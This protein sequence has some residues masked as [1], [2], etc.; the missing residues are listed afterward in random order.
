MSSPDMSRR[1]ALSTILVAGG[2]AALASCGQPKTE[3]AD[4]PRAA[5]SAQQPIVVTDQRGK[6]LTFDKPVT[7]VV[8]IPMPAASLL[9]A[10]D[11]SAAHLAAMHNASWLAM[12]DG[13][14]GKL[15][16]DAL[17]IPHDVAAN[18][19]TPN[20]ESIRALNPDVVVQW[21][22]SQ[23]T[24]PLENAGL[25]VLGLTNT[26]KQEDVDAWTAMFAAML[27]KPDRAAQIKA[28]SDR[29]RTNIMALTASRSRKGPSILYFNRFTG[30][31]K[32]A[33]NASYNDFYIKLV[34]GTNPASGDQGAKGSGMV[35]VDV[36]Q[37]LAWDPEVLLLG[38]FDDA[39]PADITSDPV[40]KDVSA[41]RDRR[42]YKVPLGGYRWDPPGQ[43]SPLMWRWLADIAFPDQTV[44]PLRST[45]VDDY[46]FL[47]GREPSSAD[48]DT[49]LWTSVN[50]QSANYRQ[51][52]G[53]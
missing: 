43:E 48:I 29:T 18:D 42:V 32:V 52:N 28:R 50:G 15:F 10:V 14:M 24:E 49:M 36:E 26:G 38:N 44:S 39:L 4:T 27:G 33:G 40:W 22:D 13:I 1:S 6:T 12:R 31:L 41:V 16:P 9:V 17:K 53:A 47:Y 8:T 19:F 46:K 35:G 7:L 5:V 20:V 45:I 21:S 51:F 11:Q 2:A 34:G 23:F 25:K 37:V 30:G 3:P